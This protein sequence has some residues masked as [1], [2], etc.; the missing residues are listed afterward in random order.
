MSIGYDARVGYGFDKSRSSSRC[1]NKCIYA[2]EGFKKN[3][4]TRTTNINSVI[5][6][7]EEL[8]ED[9]YEEEKI[10][11]NFQTKEKK[12]TEHEKSDKHNYIESENIIL[13]KEINNQN[14]CLSDVTLNENKLKKHVIFYGSKPKTDQE[15]ES[16]INIY[17]K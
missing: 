10:D 2:W 8:D 5:E 15:I 9:I 4:C 7:F 14:N 13:D 6:K 3:L 17:T 12:T 1:F 11:I 16:I